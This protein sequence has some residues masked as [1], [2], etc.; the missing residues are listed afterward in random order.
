MDKFFITGL[1]GKKTLEGKISISGAKN[2]ILK[3]IPASILFKDEVTIK[4]AS[5]Y[6]DVKNISKMMENAG[7]VVSYNSTKNQIKVDSRKIHT[8]E[9]DYDIAKKIR[10]SIVATGPM[11]ARFGKVTFPNPGGCVI[12]GRFV[13]LFL[14]GYRKMGAEV[15]L[16]GDKYTITAPNGKLKGAE[17]IFNRQTVGG[18]ETLMLA[19][20]LAKGKTVLKNCAMEP[21]IEN[22]AKYLNSCGAKIKGA[23]TTTIEITGG[24]LLKSKGKPYIVMPDRIETGSFLILGA[25][26][27]NNLTIENCNPL[28][29]EVLISILKDAGVPI[30]VKK[31]QILITNNGKIDNGSFRVEAKSLVT[32]EY[33]G[34]STDVQPQLAVFL[35][36]TK[37]ENIIFETI[38][39]G[40]FKYTQDLIKMGAK[41]TLMNTR[42]IMIHD[43]VELKAL[44]LDEDL[45]AYDIRAGFAMVI[46]S[47]IAK[48]NSSIVDVH[49]IDR[50]YE[51]LE[52][53]IRSIGGKM[54]R[55]TV[56]S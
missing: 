56:H 42:E 55:V 34:L 35:S 47:L 27:A 2:D 26:C 50:G 17:I 14:D 32:H 20:V 40:R 6:D 24:A 9:L 22:L 23:G 29:L 30:T 52:E 10:A 44:E 49:L 12:G 28:H 1:G 5:Q 11:L 19:A 53:K 54:E 15:E 7:A 36:Q 41:I 16:K 48:G 13:D 18:T 37:G 43:G 21:E 39:D 38:F 4:N 51:K 3:A 31:D 46:A 33:P 45:R 25:L 8:Q